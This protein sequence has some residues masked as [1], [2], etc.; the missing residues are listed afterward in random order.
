MGVLPLPFPWMTFPKR[1]F[2]V[3]SPSLYAFLCC[4]P[5]LV[6]ISM[7]FPQAC[8]H[9]YVVS[10]SL[11]A[12]LC[13]FP[14]LVCISMLFPQACMHFYVVSPKLVCISMLFPQAC[15]HF[16]VV[17]PSLYAFLCCFPKLVCISMLFPEACMHFQ[18]TKLIPGCSN[19]GF[20]GDISR[21]MC[22][23]QGSQ[24]TYP[25][26]CATCRVHTNLELG[27][28]TFFNNLHH[29]LEN[30]GNLKIQKEK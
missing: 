23:V 18:E 13:C 21:E 16:Y 19:R 24:G 25:G 6:C 29:F 5:K 3:V 4:F 7:L 9:F 2:Y 22:H 11:Y 14:K 8:M 20:P 28:R 27:K 12:F 15:M 10:Q 1:Y 30:S 26:R 17:S